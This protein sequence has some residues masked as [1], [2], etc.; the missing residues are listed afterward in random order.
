[1]GIGNSV[2][3]FLVDRLN[4]DKIILTSET[5]SELLVVWGL[6]GLVCFVLKISLLYLLVFGF[7]PLQ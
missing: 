1:M 7:L 4:L 5:L 6:F 2:T 3:F